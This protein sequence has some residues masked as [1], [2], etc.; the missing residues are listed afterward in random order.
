MDELQ[1]LPCPFL[2]T[3]T[4][5][6]VLAINSE[7]LALVGGGSD[8]WLN[9]PM[10]NLFPL[11]SRIFLQTHVWPM[12]LREETVREIRLQICNSHNHRL[13]VLVNCKKAQF[14][15]VDC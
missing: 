6:R 1:Q 10:D 11:P 5:G 7:L 8:D 9:K 2:S 12:L 3:D 15:G 14:Q 13:P 4:T